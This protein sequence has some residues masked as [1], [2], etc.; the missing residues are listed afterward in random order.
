NRRR[1]RIAE[2]GERGGKG[3]GQAEPMKI[4]QDDSFKAPPW[5]C[6]GARRLGSYGTPR[7]SGRR[8]RILLTRGRR[9][10]SPSRGQRACSPHRRGDAH[11]DGGRWE[12]KDDARRPAVLK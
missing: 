8:E 7:V 4:F 2:L 9:A 12:V 5:R 1:T 10:R 3:R 6:K 11:M